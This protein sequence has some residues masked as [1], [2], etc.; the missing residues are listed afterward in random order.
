MIVLSATNSGNEIIHV[1]HFKKYLTERKVL[2]TLL[3]FY[4]LWGCIMLRGE[5]EENALLGPLWFVS[6][7]VGGRPMTQHFMS[8]MLHAA[9]DT[10]GWTPTLG[11]GG[12]GPPS[13]PSKAPAAPSPPP[14]P[15]DR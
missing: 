14:L 15:L 4:Y 6:R 10:R 3:T 2:H 1:K 13:S 5:R 11:L 9:P 12:P 8:R 7:G